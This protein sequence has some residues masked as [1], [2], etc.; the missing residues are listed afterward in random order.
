[1]ARLDVSDVPVMTRDRDISRKHQAALLRQLLRQLRVPHVSVTTPSY[2]GAYSVHV[3]LPRWPYQSRPGVADN[4]EEDIHQFEELL[5][6]AFPEHVDRPGDPGH[7]YYPPPKWD[8][9]SAW[10]LDDR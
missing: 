6:V 2:S 10:H 5:T 4:S 8:I 7:D 3:T 9:Q 1:M